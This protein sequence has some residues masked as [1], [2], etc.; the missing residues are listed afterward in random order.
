MTV[1]RRVIVDH[2][3][4]LVRDLTV[5]QRFYEAVLAPLGFGVVAQDPT[6]CAFGVDGADDFGIN[7][8]GPGDVPT[9]AAHVAFVAGSRAAV[10]AF[11][12]AAVR[13]GATVKHEPTLHA[14]YHA[15]YYAAF[16]Y[17]PDGNNIEAVYH[18]PS[19]QRD[20]Q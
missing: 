7:L 2:V 8:V 18:G 15:E 5:S 6:S 10:H 20:S 4:L 9:A 16:V 12:D 19:T 14:S 17:D 13:S 11:F 1:V 3:D